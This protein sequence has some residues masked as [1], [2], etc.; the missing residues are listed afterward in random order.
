MLNKEYYISPDIRSEF[1]IIKKNCNELL[2]EEELINKLLKNKKD[3]IPLRIK[4]GLDP[5]APDIHLGHTV[6]LNKLKQLQELGHK[7][8]FLIGDFTAM[9]GDPSGR[10]ATRPS[11]DLEQVEYNAATYCSQAYKILNPDLTEIRY[12]SEW[13]D[14]LGSRGIVKLAASCTLAR[15]LER[16]DF[17]KRF[18]AREP[19]SVHEFLYPIMQGYDSVALKADIEI[20]GTDQKFNL[21]MGREL[22]KENGQEQQSILTMPLLIGIDG[23][24]KMSKSKGNY[25]GIEESSDSMFGKL[26]SIS[27]NLMWHYFDLLSF[28]SD[29]DID[30]LRKNIDEGMNPR[31]IKVI[32][33][34]EIVTRFHSDKEA[35]Q[36]LINF[37]NLFCKREV[38]S[39]LLE[40]NLGC[41]PINIIKV[42][43]DSGLVSSASEA[44]RVIEQKGVKVNGDKIESKS[45]QLSAGAY[46]IQVGKRKFIKAILV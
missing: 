27:D 37:E 38:P 29:K 26:M 22:Q 13:F 7:I 39:N 16:D 20:G 8:I 42:L 31:D 11:L 21:L 9:I 30:K 3:R 4:L 41:A 2:V 28:Q 32:L 45:L 25:I 1:S 18:K 34:K 17:T 44:Q 43:R 12:N 19:I 5:T 36:A 46:T 15:I 23:I 6:V 24:E 33:A 14:K 40:I 35:D 10:K